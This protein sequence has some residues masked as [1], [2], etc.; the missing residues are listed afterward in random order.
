MTQIKRRKHETRGEMISTFALA[1]S[2][3]FFVGEARLYQDEGATGHALIL[4]LCGI[5]SLAGAL[6][7]HLHNL[8]RWFGQYRK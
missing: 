3:M 2:G 6:R 4:G 5:L 8:W 1:I 7:F